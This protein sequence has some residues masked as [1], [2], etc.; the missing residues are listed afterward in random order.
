[1]NC[2]KKEELQKNHSE[3]K[4]ETA[5]AENWRRSVGQGVTAKCE[6]VDDKEHVRRTMFEKH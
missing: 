5:G 2:K 3:T 4:S 6:S 1:L